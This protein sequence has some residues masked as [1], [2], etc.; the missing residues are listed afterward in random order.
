MQQSLSAQ[1][2]AARASLAADK[3]KPAIQQLNAFEQ[4]VSGQD[5]IDV[6]H[7]QTSLWSVSRAFGMT[8]E[9]LAAVDS[10]EHLWCGED[11]C[12]SRQTRDEELVRRIRSGDRSAFDQLLGPH[13]GS[14]STAC[15]PTCKT[16]LTSKTLSRNRCCAHSPSC[17]SCVRQ[18]CG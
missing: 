4:E 18:D 11:R 15:A 10:M 8:L 1:V 7:D 17:I 9:L 3:I 16:M 2:E 12:C 6:L 5:K 14:C 13:I